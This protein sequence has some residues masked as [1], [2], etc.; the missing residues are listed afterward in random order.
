MFA[1]PG[2]AV[3]RLFEAWRPQPGP[4]LEPSAG[5][6]SIIRTAKAL[7]LEN[8][9]YAVECRAQTRERLDEAG[10]RLVWIDD[11]LTWDPPPVTTTVEPT[12]VMTNPPFALCE[13]FVR[14]AETLFPYADLCFLVRLGFLASEERL[15]L[16]SD[17]GVPD[18]YVLPNRPSFT[19]DGST[20]SADY[21]WAIWPGRVRRDG[22]TVRILASTP[23]EVRKPVGRSRRAAT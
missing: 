20:D 23:L 14:R 4:I 22:G 13:A 15:R 8:P 16:W 1:T 12:T 11:F 10:A 7:G 19:G 18:V 6:G 5:S 2:W 17:V 21:A 3:A 9:W